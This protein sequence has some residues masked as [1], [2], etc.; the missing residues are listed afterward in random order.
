MNAI[1]GAGASQYTCWMESAFVTKLAQLGSYNLFREGFEGIAWDSV[2]SIEDSTPETGI[3]SKGIVWKTNF[4]LTN[5]ITTGSGSQNGFWGGLDPNH[6]DPDI[7]YLALGGIEDAF[8]G[9]LC[10]DG[11]TPISDACFLHDGLSGSGTAL[12]AVGG[13]FS[14]IGGTPGNIS[15]VLDSGSL[16]NIGKKQ[17]PDYEFFG[18]IETSGFTSFQ[19]IE[20]DGKYGQE[21]P[22]FMD[23]F[24][25]ATTGIVE[26]NVAPVLTGIGSRAVD[27]GGALNFTLIATDVNPDDSWSFSADTLPTGASVVDNEDGTS[28]FHWSPNYIQSGNYLVTFTVTDNGFPSKSA[29][30]QVSITVNDI[31]RPPVLSNIGNKTV[32][33]EEVLTFQLSASELDGDNLS[34]SM[35][36]GATGVG[37]DGSNL[38][39][40]GNGT[41]TFSWL[42]G[43][44]QVTSHFVTFTVTDDGLPTA[45]SDFEEISISV[46]TPDITPPVLTLPL[47][48]VA[49]ATSSV[50][51]VVSYTAT[52]IDLVDGTLPS[53]CAPASGSTFALGNTT[54][55]CSVT[56][57][58]NNTATGSFTVTVQDTTAPAVT[59][60][61]DITL[62]A[63]GSTTAVTLG[64]AS[65]IDLVSG[66]L[67]P[68][69]S[70]SGPFAVGVHQITWSA[71]DGAN[72]TGTAIQTVTI[73]DTG[74]PT[75]TLPA[76]ITE[77]ATSA[78]GALVSYNSSASDTVDGVLPSGCAPASGSTFALGITPVNCSVTD[79]ANNTATG[80]FTVTVEDTTA[81][82]VTV[83]ADIVME[84]TGSTTAVAL[85]AAS[86]SDLVSGSLTPTAS[87]SGP[88]AVGVHQITWSATD[89]ANNTGTAIQT[90]TITDTGA[91][92]LTLPGNITE[93]ATSASGALVSYSSSASD[94][95]DG[96]L[97]S[98]CA[99][100]SGSTF[101]L[102]NT[103]VNCSVTDTANNTATGSFTVTV[104]DTTA[105]TVTVSAD[106]VMEAT[107]STT[108]VTLGAASASDLVSGSLTPTAS[109][110][111]PFAVGVHQITWSATDGANNT[112]T[113]IQTVTIADTGAPVL[114]LPINI[115]EEATSSLG[116]LVSYSS[117][118]SDTVDGVL[119]SGCSPASGSAFALGNTTVNCSVTDTANNTATGSFTVTVEDTTAPILTLPANINREATSVAGALVNY[120]TS[121]NDAV[122]SGLSASCLPASGS[123][124]VLGSTVVNCS[125]TDTST[126]SISGS[127]T[128]TISD[129]GAPTLT[130]P[131]NITS[132]A[133]S[134]LGALVNY[135][136]SAVD[137]VDGALTPSCLP[138]SGSTFALGS[139]TVSC[140][141][142][143][144]ESNTATD[145]FI[146]T[147]IDST[148]PVLSLPAN[149]SQE[150]T[151]SAGGL[152]TYNATAT[153]IVDGVLSPICLPASGSTFALGVTEVNCSVTDIATNTIS[154]SFT[155]TITDTNVPV[156]T[157]P[158]NITAEATSSA[159]SLVNYSASASDTVDGNMPSGC[160]PVSG[161]TFALGSTPVNC[162]V[163]D[164]A[165]NTST[166]SFTITVEDT[167]AP[168]VT[169][170]LDIV[171]EASGSTT[172]VTLGT[173]SAS[174]LVSG[175][176]TPTA[177]NSGPFAV[178][179][180]QITWS[181]TDGANNTG[182][183]I[184]AVTITDTGAP[185]LTL[186]TNITEE[187]TSALGALVSYN[188]SAS[189]TV[190]GTLPSGCAP[191]SGSI[192]ALGTTTV[193]C[194]V[195]D[196]ES[197]TTSGSFEILVQDLTAPTVTAPLDITMEATGL[198][199]AVTL[200]SASASDLVDGAVIPGASSN[201]P[202]AVGVHQ[203]TWSATDT[204]GNTGTAVQMVTIT[205]TGAPMLTLPA[206]I[207]KE[208]T[209]SAGALVNYSASASD[210]VDGVLPSGCL[211]VS[212]S[213]F[214]LSATT[215]NCSV[216][217]SANNTSSGSF[218][219]TVQDTTAPTVTAPLDIVMEA[220]GATTAV[221][222]GN[223]SASD[224]V[225]G[226]LIASA[227]IMGPFTVGVH[228]ITW[229][230]TDTA[231][232][233]GTDI[234][235]VTINDTGAP[236]LTLPANITEEATSTS[237]A[238]VNYD[239]S[240]SDIVDGILASGC[241][242][243]SGSSFAL[244]S[245]TVNC[246]V[247]DS[248]NNIS[249]GSFT[250]IV[251]DTTAPVLTLPSNINSQA[252]SI[253]GVIVNYSASASDVV[254][255]NLP[256]SCLPASG[257]TFALG[258]TVVNCSAIDG[259]GNT[260]SASF[261]ITVED[262]IAPIL[263]LPANVSQE[264]SSSAGAI[265]NYSATSSDAVDG[266]LIPDCLPVSGSTF[267]VG[268]TT[269]NCSVMDNSNNTTT[270]SFTVSITDTGAPMLTLPANITAE[271]TSSAG[272]IVNY[273]AE[274]SDTVDGSITPVCIPSSGSVFSLGVDTIV[275]CSVQDS[276]FNT[277]TGNFTVKV[278]DTTAPTVTASFDITMEATGQTT[279]VIL[280]D[281]TASDI[282][283]GLLIPENNNSG[284]FTVGV[285]QVTWS[286]SDSSANIG[287]A[288]QTV[289]ITDS[290]APTLI[291]PANIS[292]EATSSTG[293]TVNYNVTSSDVVDGLLIPD[294]L[295]ASGSVFPLGTSP[296]NCSVIDNANNSTSAMFSITITDTGV[297]TLTLSTNL[298]E[299][300]TSSAGA[301]V[302]Y[303]VSANDSIDG[304]ITPVCLPQSGNTFALGDTAVH[305]SAQDS[306]Q[307]VST[308]SF[309]ITVE[310]TTSPGISA[311]IDIT[312]EAT[313]STTLVN[314]GSASATDLVDG[315]LNPVANNTGPFAV[316]V[317]QVVWSVSD[318]STNTSSATQVVTITDSVS[319]S[320]AIPDNMAVEAT[321][322]A[323]ATVNYSV[324][325]S[326]IVD[327]VLSPGCLPASGSTFA[328]G[329]TTVNC[330]VRDA[331]TNISS[332]SFTV[333]VED[334]TAPVV[335]APL[336][337]TVEASGTTTSVALGTATA[338]D[339][340]SGQLIPDADNTGPFTVGMHQITWSISD[341]AGNIGSAIQLVTITDNSAPTLTLPANMTTEATS[342]SG[343]TVNFSVTASD[344]VDA[345]IFP[346][347][348]PV[349]GSTFALGS[350]TVNCSAMDQATNTSS[351]SF[352]VM[353]EDTSAPV[354]MAPLD[355]VMEA[356][357][358]IT[359]VT[360]GSATATD[361]VDGVLIPTANMVG[362][363]S[364][365]IHTITWS[366]SDSAMNTGT[367]IQTVTITDTVAPEITLNGASSIMLSIG[368]MYQELGANAV[369]NVDSNVVVSISGTV[370][371]SVSGVYNILYTASDTAGNS[372]TI[373]RQ[374]IVEA[375]S[376][377]VATADNAS[378]DEDVA[379]VINVLL[380]D[381]DKDGDSLSVTH[382]TQGFNGLVEINND[383][384]LTYMPEPNFNGSD[385]FSYT[386]SDDKGGSAIATVTISVISINDAPIADAG[387]DLTGNVGNAVMLDGS[388]SYDPEGANLSYE[389][390][391]LS[392]PDNSV[393]DLNDSKL[394]SPYFVP[395]EAGTYQLQ[396]TVN[397]GSVDSDPVTRIIIVYPVYVTITAPPAITVDAEGLLTKLSIDDLQES[398]EASAINNLGE[399]VPVFL[400]N[401]LKPFSPGHHEVIWVA[402]DSLGN[403][404]EAIQ[405]VNVQ[406][407]VEFRPVQLTTP[408]AIVKIPVLLNGN[409]A[410][411]PVIVSYRIESDSDNES[412][413]TEYVVEI[414]S[415]TEGEIEYTV[416]DDIEEGEIKF[417]IRSAVNA[418]KGPQSEHKLRVI[419]KG[420]NVSPI[421]KLEI[422]QDGK[423][424]RIVFANDESVSVKVKVHDT[425]SDDHH[426]F[427]WSKTDEI[428]FSTNNDIP[429]ENDDEFSFDPENLNAGFYKIAVK[430]E[431]EGGLD[432]EVEFFLEV[433]EIKEDLSDEEDSDGDGKDDK[434][435][436]YDDED[437][438]GIP[439]YEDGVDNPAAMQ[440]KQGRSDKWL[441]NVQP[442]LGIRLGTIPLFSE[443]YTANVTSEE[444]QENAGKNEDSKPAETKDDHEN[445][446]GYFDFEIN[447]LA[448][449]GQSVMIVIPQY[450]EIPEDA[451]YRK[452]SKTNGWQD[453]VEDDKN[454]LS[455]AVGEEGICPAPGD[456]AYNHNDGL[457]EGD[458]C[459]QLLIEDGGPND[460]DGR[461]N[462]VILDPGGVSIAP[463]P[464]KP[465]KNVKSSSGGSINFIVLIILMSLFGA[466]LLLR[467]RALIK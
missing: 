13:Y 32:L 273:I 20:V 4:P 90:V 257:N 428:L 463:E 8:Y 24:V 106:I 353:V 55:N 78:S 311:P 351:G 452:Y 48:I 163:T 87:N 449:A 45:A 383:G 202:F 278:E 206:N 6:G 276:E 444:I 388:G 58:A 42:P 240:A 154:G 165:N 117:S 393:V 107:G 390:L 460:T 263:N 189:D 101:A 382:V 83:S 399:D 365:G 319:P 411:Y 172:A 320:L 302:N 89:G 402:N 304:N 289:T 122:D 67:N 405:F 292:L 296:V 443:R 436:G 104:Q 130:L 307:N 327:G 432:A 152:V 161:S 138:T 275:N 464:T 435:E 422:K 185:S 316:G 303:I 243:A 259:A 39:D 248:A 175:S 81:P 232:N 105:P 226:A 17:V 455:S 114:T 457:V 1:G 49:E 116:S 25:I 407:Y 389:W 264:A 43:L 291:V 430:V 448:W 249:N 359:P 177:S 261:M 391:I 429:G 416:P 44:N 102:G 166:G 420:H 86:A 211:P 99:P 437:D 76:N 41:A 385:S 205:D 295:P 188:S 419:N 194:S 329:I 110:S 370:N 371:T 169:A 349:S 14:D 85:G 56:D 450:T 239:A 62:E 247:S 328:F 119:P 36:G 184:Q 268:T 288:I 70:N 270:G 219:V 178:G 265:V 129:T 401:I 356:T 308:G 164:N 255:G 313:G 121:A 156:L 367:A 174:D 297:P 198:T 451:V 218:I 368:D 344:T 445:K 159:G 61:L 285:H 271:A 136:V 406:P 217:D 96:T 123:T 312:M 182:T 203:I 380:N 392:R 127:F 461:K 421:A 258:D 213:T 118:A 26:T 53:G 222:L 74:A 15:V 120:S 314:L 346:I 155:V 279:V 128:V 216:M 103:T 417:K 459:V 372:M 16:L 199:T 35:S 192:F 38:V 187:A 309:I 394:Q 95:V 195:T 68:A 223:A 456:P 214:A 115:T 378:T 376:I 348:I 466:N 467:K 197:N 221:T 171:M 322:L 111:G 395:D 236:T 40:H 27:E 343:A 52:A 274:A 2:R 298:I 266:S 133:T 57:T 47:A 181:A 11:P 340:V 431:D 63:T 112:G 454:S 260:S 71:T 458:Y 144:A 341:T 31:N 433:R 293:A 427:D 282:V 100:T 414:E 326:D 23:D 29:S 324:T 362:P 22:I 93:E 396:L 441:L 377:P 424:T 387:P 462:G 440:G 140:S 91:P 69:A 446:G 294:C 415:G 28:T 281:A 12:F 373:K 357:G 10:I 77:E 149:I 50:G 398:G 418:V 21:I 186:P 238:L 360:L 438:D 397:D 241:L 234:Q 355:I 59:A 410:V 361:L 235:T 229:S 269:V 267:A 409:A 352:T 66:S 465:V 80:S 51:A 153:D 386:V 97:S 447:G 126:N 442:G 200:G 132:E 210:T 403:P 190:D 287:F 336:D 145:S 46:T 204:A 139:T 191:V 244:G 335:T 137:T 167:T 5:G 176:L 201:G 256:A 337:I 347:C 168:I 94:T 233:I 7:P 253:A 423:K 400:K 338:L 434:E 109:N 246:S 157:L 301:V 193:N 212:G 207:T 364:V 325:A 79:T 134:S 331:A 245:T 125:V 142:N 242:P 374:V 84:A 366:A 262:V 88:F 379:V 227:D 426:T 369:D 330:D 345:S 384:T 158:A 237:G 284:P 75:L 381:Q 286:V 299:E 317:H 453:F 209:S 146:V 170:P 220:T 64:T 73:T 150:A 342:A 215:V 250:V 208:A 34:F 33:V 173:A 425:N 131:A 283:D 350:T 231:G 147:I 148:A 272:A 98:G 141:V 72:N 3:E 37:P 251:Q 18:I 334:S 124:F 310:D 179:V 9:P 160:L 339:Q 196:S 333:N 19:F 82:T 290:V 280:G 306:E 143:D 54:V 300:A 180:H 224:L 375:N 60:P 363:F 439:D 412:E 151:S 404:A 277:S 358:V 305:C 92:A 162:S 323:G 65:A 252:T 321:S 254:D 413:N 230:A 315:I 332:G 408:A 228:Q 113:A 135:S 318:A 354:V 108:A 225:S 183:A 30:E